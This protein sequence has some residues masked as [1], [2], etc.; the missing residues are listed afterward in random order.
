LRCCD[1]KLRNGSKNSGLGESEW[2]TIVLEIAK[3]E[4]LKGG[5]PH[6]IVVEV[7]DITDSI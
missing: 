7:R 1:E 2:T 6:P 5:W 3:N 4:K